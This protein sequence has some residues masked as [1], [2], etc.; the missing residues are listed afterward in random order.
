MGG[1]FWKSL[2]E[3]A[4]GTMVDAGTISPKDLEIIRPAAD[5]DEAVKIIE[6]AHNGR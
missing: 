3:F 1:D 4:R 5:V 6:T 2:R